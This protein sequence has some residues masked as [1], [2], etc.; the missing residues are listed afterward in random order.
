MNSYLD[1]QIQKAEQY[2]RDNTDSILKTSQVIDKFWSRHL[3]SKFD[4]I[5]LR[6]LHVVSKVVCEQSGLEVKRPPLTHGV[7]GSS[8]CDSK[9]PHRLFSGD[10][11]RGV[12]CE[13]KRQAVAPSRETP[14]G[15][16]LVF[17][18]MGPL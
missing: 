11:E 4:G 3:Y 13:S 16:S 12:F 18:L 2:L 5:N 9:K 14:S 10:F 15:R 7:Q 8:P 6:S 1:K 17:G